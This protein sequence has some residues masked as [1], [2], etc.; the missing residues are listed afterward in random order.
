M[1]CRDLLQGVPRGAPE[2]LRGARQGEGSCRRSRLPGPPHHAH[3]P[4]LP[5]QGRGRQGRTVSSVPLQRPPRLRSKP[6]T[7]HT[8]THTKKHK[9]T[10]KKS[11]TL[12]ACACAS[13]ALCWLARI[14]PEHMKGCG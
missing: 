3:R 10:Q 1:G 5:H 8:H 12:L 6:Y 11:T 7:P 4:R 14:T 9:N 13:A 2:A